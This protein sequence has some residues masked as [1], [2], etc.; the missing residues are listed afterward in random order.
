MNV[1]SA[2]SHLGL[3]HVPIFLKHLV[4]YTA[5]RIVGGKTM[6]IRMIA[7]RKMRG[8]CLWLYGVT[9]VSM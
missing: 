2:M 8:M 5:R 6:K 1:C 4:G 7:E 9:V 3:R